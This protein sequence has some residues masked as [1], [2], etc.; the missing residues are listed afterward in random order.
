M[1]KV[2]RL[3]YLVLT[4]VFMM[5]LL[6]ACKKGDVKETSETK[7]ETKDNGEKEE[8]KQETK[9]ENDKHN[10]VT[11]TTVSMHGGTDP[12]AANYQEINKKFMN[13]YSYITIEDDSQT[14]DQDWKT[15]IA[16]DFAVGNEPDVIQFFTDANASD[17]LAADKFVTIEEI[18]AEYP[19]YAK[20]TL[21]AA[22]E[23]AVNPDGVQRAVP[24][25]GFWEGLFCNKDLFDKYN[26]ELPTDWDKM[27][28]AI[29]TFK[30]NDIIPIAV[31]LNNVPHYWV[32]F[33]MLAAAGPE[34]FTTVPESA[35]EDWVKGLEMFKTLRDLGAFPVD[36]DTIDN[37][38][39]GELFKNKQAA[40][41]L[42]GSWYAGGIPDQDN[43]VVVSFPVIPGGKAEPGFMVGGLSSG[44]YITKKAWN[45]P[46]KRD[47][48]VK[49]VMAHTCSESVQ[50]Y[51]N[52]NGTAAAKVEPLADM[53]PLGISGLNYSSAATS[54]STPTDARIKQEAYN[55][56]TA[57]IVD[58]STGARTPADL[59]EEVLQ[60]NAR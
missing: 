48:A 18:K 3:V 59:I 17:V 57:G 33:L 5:S 16:A 52:G 10:P 36:T 41:Q 35:P 34:G 60:V 29:E 55:T 23:A 53:T 42:D 4:V 8:N 45:D 1:R 49:F 11:L 19:D 14:S 20:D 25:T 9:T 30:E 44:F 58:V 2:K 47:A 43:T 38:F 46:D 32:E 37:D 27:L 7:Q 6:A 40:M 12:N 39:A 50:K 51:W 22:L 31:S 21:P 54:I 15:K 24:T 13:D 56:L 28:K 26:L